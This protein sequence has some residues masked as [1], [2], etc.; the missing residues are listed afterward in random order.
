MRPID[1]LIAAVVAAVLLVGAVYVLLVSPQRSQASSLSAQI[2]TEQGA[3]ASAQASL[4]AARTAVTGYGGDVKQLAEVVEAVPV[5]VDEPS[6]IR[7]ITKLAGTAVDV[8]QLNV[9]G[10]TGVSQGPTALGLSFTFNATYGSLQSFIATLDRL[11]ST[12]GTNL[13]ANGRLFTI[14][15]ITFTPNGDK[16]NSSRAS[17]T[18]A[19]YSQTPG[20]FGGAAAATGG[21]SSTAAVTP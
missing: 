1:K 8:H 11:V 17:V 20:V 12:D 9:A 14:A 15:G 13:A 6:V 16:I 19:S 10:G 18:A 5:N 2:A 4:A 3:L 21:V 7:T